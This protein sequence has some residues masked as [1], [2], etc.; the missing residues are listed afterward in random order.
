[1]RSRG[2][3]TATQDPER[4]IHWSEEDRQNAQSLLSHPG[5]QSLLKPYIER[6][7]KARAE[8]CLNRLVKDQSIA[9]Q[10]AQDK[11][12]IIGLTLIVGHLQAI[13]KSGSRA[14]TEDNP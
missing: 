11:G 8:S 1:M 3:S 6:Q 14:P 12:V 9:V 10:D 5:W 2:F 7:T 4:P 13:I